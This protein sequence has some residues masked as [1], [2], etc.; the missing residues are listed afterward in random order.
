MEDKALTFSFNDLVKETDNLRNNLVDSIFNDGYIIISVKVSFQ[1][2]HIIYKCPNV[3]IYNMLI[4]KL[5]NDYNYDNYILAVYKHY[6]CSDEIITDIVIPKNTTLLEDDFIDST[7]PKGI[8]SLDDL[9][10]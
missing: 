3:E 10:F 4:N 5:E 7:L 8:G 9:P 6:H 1:D 2:E